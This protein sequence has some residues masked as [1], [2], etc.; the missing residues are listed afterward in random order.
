[1]D[2]KNSYEK[3][4]SYF[5]PAPRVK[6]PPIFRAMYFGGFMKNSLPLTDRPKGPPSPP[7]HRP[8]C[9]CYNWMNL[10]SNLDLIIAVFE[11]QLS[12]VRFWSH[13]FRPRNP[14]HDE[15]RTVWHDYYS[16]ALRWT[17][18]LVVCWFWNLFVFE[19]VW[20]KTL[21]EVYEG[22]KKCSLQ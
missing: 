22:G 18:L 14:H 21:E 20:K 8:R 4:S 9:C 19:F 11:F 7:S 5:T 16:G 2:P 10:R 13:Q 3:W 17:E 6:F 1:M 12:H 15:G